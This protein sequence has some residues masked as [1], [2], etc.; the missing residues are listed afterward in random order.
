M[1]I[2]L[3]AAGTRR[4]LAERTQHRPAV[5]MEMIMDVS[6]RDTTGSRMDMITIDSVKDPI[7]GGRM[8]GT[9]TD[10]VDTIVS[11]KATIRTEGT[12]MQETVKVEQLVFPA[13]AVVTT[14]KDSLKG[15][16]GSGGRSLQ[17]EDIIK[18]DMIKDSTRE[19]RVDLSREEVD[20]SREEVD[21]SREG[22]GMTM[23]E[24]GMMVVEVIMTEAEGK[25][26]MKVR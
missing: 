10:R 7:M 14:R 1:M 23:E 8:A 24:V 13:V 11:D 17:M 19:Y 16:M 5:V 26:D 21:M 3:K 6:K 9:I 22:E 18:Q 25:E 12:I 2:F 15:R 4:L 20:M